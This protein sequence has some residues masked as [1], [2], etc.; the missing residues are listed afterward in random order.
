MFQVMS[1]ICTVYMNSKL[2]D[3]R[4]CS[5]CIEGGNDLVNNTILLC[6]LKVKFIH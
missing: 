6:N 3:I 4:E 2:D 1:S 5:E